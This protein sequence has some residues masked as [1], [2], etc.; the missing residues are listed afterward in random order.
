M[1]QKTLLPITL[2]SALLLGAQAFAQEQDTLDYREGYSLIL[3]QQWS[4]AQ[5]YFENFRTQWP[6]SVW[7]DDAAFW[8]CYAI[9]QEQS[10]QENHFN[11]Y[12]QFVSDFA[13]ST[14]VADA[15]TKLAVL[16]SQLAALGNP[17]YLEELG[18]SW[19]F[20]FDVDWDFDAEELSETV[21]RAMELA[22]REMSQVAIVLENIELPEVPEIPDIP[23][24]RGVGGFGPD[25]REWQARAQEM[26]ARAQEMVWRRSSGDDELLALVGALR[27]DARVSEILMDR[28]ESTENENLRARI[29]LLLEDL[30]GENINATLL[31]VLENDESDVVR[32]SAVIALL[33]RDDGSSR[34]RFFEIAMD[35]TYPLPVRAQIIGEMDNWESD[36][37]LD[38][39]AEILEN[40]THP[41][42]VAEAADALSDMKTTASFEILSSGFDSAESAELR[43][44]ILNEIA[45]YE[46]P[47]TLSFLNE[48]ALSEGDDEMAAIAI[49]GIADREDNIGVAALENIYVNSNNLQ[50][51]LAALDGIGN[52]ESQQAVEVLSTIVAD[53]Q[54]FQLIAGAVR[55]LGDTDLE[56]AVDPVYTAYL[57]NDNELVRRGVVRALRRLQEFPAAREAMLEILEDRLNETDAQ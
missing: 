6:D 37:A 21:E 14:W 3:E 43:Y 5:N 40:E 15:R 30:P 29:V 18:A 35:D 34:E 16:G 56:T 25:Q 57:D 44:L 45:D 31:D 42:L 23:E 52:A 36:E 1:K 39:L 20:D 38:A 10:D 4:N 46:S 33:D 51:Q 50:R 47:E 7:T 12:Q 2:G 54:D 24:I 48:I 8:N 28:L 13:G 17:A 22:E 19:E 55:A 49:E 11:C 53:E 27:D 41:V 32:N 9:E 26:A